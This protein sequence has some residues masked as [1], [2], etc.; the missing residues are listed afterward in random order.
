M[1]F[2]SWRTNA[3]IALTVAAWIAVDSLVRQHRLRNRIDEIIEFHQED[4]AMAR[5]DAYEDGIHYALAN[6]EVKR[7]D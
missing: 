7:R 5:M 3:F 4:L 6:M 1:K 2:P